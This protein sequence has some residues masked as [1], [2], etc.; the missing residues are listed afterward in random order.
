[1]SATTL[2]LTIEPGM[3]EARSCWSEFESLAVAM[4]REVLL[5]A[6]EEALADAQER[7]IDSVCGPRWAP[8][9]GLA[10]PFACPRWEMVEDFVRKGKRTRRR[11]LHTAAGTVALVVWNV[12]CRGCGRV[13]AP[14][15]VML[16]LS[17]KRRTD[18]LT[19]DVAELGT[20]VSFARAAGL[21]RELAGTTATVGQAHNALADTAAL[22]SGTDGTLGPGHPAP[23]VVAL[24]GTGARAGTTKNGWACIWPWA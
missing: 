11:K 18:R 6:L 2:T 1:M 20:Q 4:S 3:L 5:R 22:L 15:L 10:A 14:L 19:V 21:S 23:D 13:F 24:E 8:V 12:G 17:G 9:R 16:G 7:L